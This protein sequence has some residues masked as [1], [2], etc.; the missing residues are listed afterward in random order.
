MKHF[1]KDADFYET[2]KEIREYAKR[3]GI[4]VADACSRFLKLPESISLEKLREM[5][6][7]TRH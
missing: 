3:E 4:S 2:E 5:M 6:K 1:V 7:P